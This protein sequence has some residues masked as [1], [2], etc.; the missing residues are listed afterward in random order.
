[1]PIITDG[2]EP[3][4]RALVR[5]DRRQGSGVS[6]GAMVVAEKQLPSLTA[7]R[8]LVGGGG[9]YPSGAAM[10]RMMEKAAFLSDTGGAGANVQTT[11]PEI[12]NPLLSLINFYLPYDRKTLNQWI[13]YYSRFHPYV[14]NCIDLHGEF[15]ISD[16]HFT[17][18]SDKY[19][20]DIYEEQKEEGKLVKYAFEA[21]RE[22]E[23]L[24]EVFSF[25]PWEEDALIFGEYQILNPDLL[26]IKVIDWTPDGLIYT[27]E[28]STEMRADLRSQDPRV[29][30]KMRN[31]DPVVY[32][33]LMAGTKIPLADF[34]VMSMMRKESPYDHRGTSI[35]MKTLKD[36]MYEDKLREAQ[37]AIADQQITPAQ[38]WKLG[39][40]ANG[41][42]PTT[43]DLENFRALLQ[44]GK[45]DPLFTIVTHS[46][47]NLD[48]V[49]YTGKLLPVKEEFD[50]VAKR[51]LV[52]LFASESMMGAEGPGYSNAL[53][54]LKVIQGRYQSKRDKIVENLRKKIFTPVAKANKFF[55]TSKADLAHRTR[56]S[57]SR[58]KLVLPGIE[59]NFKLDMTDQS[60]RIQYMLQLRD[61]TQLPMKTICE[62][63]DV[64]YEPT[65]KALRDEE[66]TE[67]DPVYQAARA[68]AAEKTGTVPPTGSVGAPAP[69]EVPGLSGGAEEA[70]PAAGGAEA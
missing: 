24:G 56:T 26:D 64:P 62:V 11:S 55:E 60:Q 40:P 51:V 35:V 31:M 17:G 59:W 50:W 67:F 42:M 49:G 15:P 43:A 39:D 48:L 58:Q 45:H 54:A 6:G 33:N 9:V 69:T 28:P 63:L 16:F 12:R 41:Y 44:A 29:E 22:Y 1:M 53:V 18:I 10:G 70:A 47:V 61:K 46:A 52:G 19:I 36:L 32:E 37:Y 5:G 34:N 3:N 8:C 23:L 20:L 65:R 13:R 7:A 4:F 68:A 2:V 66:G 21:S 25:H 30:E 57:R 27:Y 14:G 38:I